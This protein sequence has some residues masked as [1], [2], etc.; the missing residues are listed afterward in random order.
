[1]LTKELQDLY[2]ENYKTWLQEIKKSHQIKS[3]IVFNGLKDLI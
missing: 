3:H 2:A 1:M